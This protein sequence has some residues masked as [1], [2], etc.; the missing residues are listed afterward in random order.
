MSY[1]E[2]K[3]ERHRALIASVHGD[4]GD[5]QPSSS[6][7]SWDGGVRTDYT[8]RP[9]PRPGPYLGPI[10]GDGWG[11]EIEIENGAELI[12]PSLRALREGD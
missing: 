10:S 7:G 4:D 12:F 5:C 2:S 3:L 6:S 9:E 11:P 8:P 1:Y